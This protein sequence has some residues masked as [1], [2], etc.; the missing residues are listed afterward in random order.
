MQNLPINTGFYQHRGR[1]VWG[2][3]SI[4]KALSMGSG[5][6]QNKINI[7]IQYTKHEQ[8]RVQPF[9]KYSSFHNTN[10]KVFGDFLNNIRYTFFRR[11]IVRLPS[12]CS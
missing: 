10:I 12:R 2:E 5:E 7:A 3:V 11:E 4:C 8:Q 6:N 9:L 1:W